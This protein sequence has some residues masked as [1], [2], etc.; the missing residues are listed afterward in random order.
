M[1]PVWPNFFIVGGQRCGTTSLHRYLGQHPDIFMSLVKEPDFFSHPDGDEEA[2]LALFRGAEGHPIVGEASTNYLTVPEA[3]GRIR[4]ACPGA[5]ILVSLRD[6]VERAHSGYLS[7]VR[8]GREDRTFLNFVQDRVAAWEE[9]GEDGFIENSAYHDHLT[10][11]LE[12]FGED[13]V[14]AVLFDHLKEDPI[15]VLKG[16][17]AFLDVDPAPM[18]DVD[19]SSAHNPFGVPRNAVAHFLRTSP[20]VRRIARLVLPRS[21]RIRLGE[22]VL[23]ERVDKPPLDP[24]AC[25][26]LWGICADQIDRVEELFGRPLPE[27]RRTQPD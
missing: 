23:L 3:A 24:K 5:R 22:D 17:A 11:L 6:P 20:T 10:R 15:D 16:I 27:L 2:Y 26:L 25:E 12:T 4:R 9:T 14:H 21:W 8:D 7:R 13:R 1:G 18:E 19:T